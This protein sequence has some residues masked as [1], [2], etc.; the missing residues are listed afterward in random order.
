M[1]SLLAVFLLLLL[2]LAAFNA[3]SKLLM[4]A[5]L[6]SCHCFTLLCRPATTDHQ[7]LK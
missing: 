1:L 2:L 7:T 3:S 4:L 6:K 5:L